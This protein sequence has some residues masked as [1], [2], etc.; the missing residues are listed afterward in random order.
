MTAVAN[1]IGDRIFKNYDE[2]YLRLLFS[3]GLVVEDVI[4]QVLVECCRFAYLWNAEKHPLKY[5]VERDGLELELARKNAERIIDY[6]RG[7]FELEEKRLKETINV[8]IL[9]PDLKL[10]KQANRYP[11]YELSEFQ[12]WELQNIHDMELIKAIVERRIRASNKNFTS[13]R[14][15]T[16]ASQYDAIIANQRKNYKKNPDS[17]V[18]STLALF[19]LETKYSFEFFYML[20]TE[21][22]AARV[23]QIPGM[24]DRLMATA[25]QYKC[26]SCLPDICP[27]YACDDDRFVQDPMILQ[28]QR[29]AKKIVN[30]PED[31]CGELWLWRIIEANV[32]ANAVQSHIRLN[33][34]PMRTW[35]AEDTD[36]DDWASVFEVYDV[37]SLFTEEKRW[38]LAKIR[39]VRKMYEGLSANYKSFS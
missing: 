24:K 3:G 9:K 15:I 7:H 17:T 30:H 38:S 14:F 13:D 8:D 22:E 5:Y 2:E 23:T 27:N 25:G 18:F 39:A 29:F 1:E 11:N 37:F 6:I 10:R 19:T 33:G 34:K 28:R 35:F 20:A 16:M 12:Y 4:F 26:T 31:G 21:M 32:L 36:I